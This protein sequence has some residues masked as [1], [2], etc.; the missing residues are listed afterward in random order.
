[1]LRFVIALQHTHLQSPKR[2]PC[3]SARAHDCHLIKNGTLVES[4]STN[5]LK[6]HCLI[7]PPLKFTQGGEVT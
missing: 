4:A 1:M 7:P 5:V 3:P 2:A 6:R